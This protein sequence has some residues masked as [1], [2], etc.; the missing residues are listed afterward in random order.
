MLQ[1]SR[2]RIFGRML[3]AVWILSGLTATGLSAQEVMVAPRPIP[4]GGTTFLPGPD[5]VDLYYYITTADPYQK[6]A[7][8]PGPIDDPFNFPEPAKEEPHGQWVSIFINNIANQSLFDPLTPFS[9]RYGSILVKE[10]YPPST[11]PPPA[12]RSTL[13]TLTV[14]Y[15]V[16]GFRTLPGQDEWFWVMYLPSGRVL[17]I[18]DQPFA[19]LPRFTPFIGEVQAG[20]P[21]FCVHCHNGARE[22]SKDAVGDFV[23]KFQPS[24]LPRDK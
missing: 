6:W 20:K 15:K 24:R 23:Y 5:A 22:T 11:G 1:A 12:D 16:R 21:W 2:T 14:M 10:N 7:T 8:L 19:R 3:I 9:M 17:E 4:T 18:S 13:E